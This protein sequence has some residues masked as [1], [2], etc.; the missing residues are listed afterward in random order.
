MKY[1]LLLQSIIKYTRKMGENT[2]SMEV[3]RFLIICADD[4]LLVA[5]VFFI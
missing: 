2:E 3:C 4:F 5:D 1:Q